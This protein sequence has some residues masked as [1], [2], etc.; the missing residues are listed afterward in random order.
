MT[1][2]AGWSILGV[3]SYALQRGL[4]DRELD[5]TDASGDPDATPIIRAPRGRTLGAAGAIVL[6]VGLGL[7]LLTAL[8][9]W[10]GATTGIGPGGGPENCAQ[11]WIGCPQATPLP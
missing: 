10:A 9:N 7:G 5:G 6:A 11:S 1:I 2:S 8:G 3:V 4:V